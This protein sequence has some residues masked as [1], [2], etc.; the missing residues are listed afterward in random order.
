MK[1]TAM[2]ELIEEMEKSPLM[3]ANAIELAEAMLEK[4]KE[5]MERVYYDSFV[6]S[7]G[8]RL[9]YDFEEYYNETFNTKER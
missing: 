9:S 4:E 7:N 6:N 1:R 3:Y 8:N 2:Q 5:V